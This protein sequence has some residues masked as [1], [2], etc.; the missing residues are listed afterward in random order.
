MSGVD[1]VLRIGSAS[2]ILLEHR[3]RPW[4]QQ[5]QVSG[6]DEDPGSLATSTTGRMASPSTQ[7]QPPHYGLGT[8]RFPWRGLG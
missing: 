1:R 4:F 5:A 8:P 2:H 7:K 3:Q 6:M